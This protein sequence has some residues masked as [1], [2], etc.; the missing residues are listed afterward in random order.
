MR[1]NLVE[2]ILF[3]DP[4]LVEINKFDAFDF[5]VDGDQLRPPL[6]ADS[7]TTI[8]IESAFDP[9]QTWGDISNPI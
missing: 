4:E 2:K 9:K 3:A 8:E 5:P 7:I 1:M 6:L